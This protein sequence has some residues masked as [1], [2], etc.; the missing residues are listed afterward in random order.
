MRSVPQM[1]L[2]PSDP[3]TGKCALHAVDDA[4]A[5]FDKALALAARAPRTLFLHPRDCHLPAMSPLPAQPAQ[6][7][8]HQHRRIQT[9]R[10]SPLAL[11]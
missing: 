4:C 1:W 8:A 6:K 5:L 11:A 7:Y 2:D 3:E 9:I 10:F